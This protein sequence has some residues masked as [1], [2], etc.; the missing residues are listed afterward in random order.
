[1]FQDC[2]DRY[3]GKFKDLRI[4]GYGKIYYGNGDVYE[5]TLHVKNG[6]QGFGKLITMKKGDPYI[7]SYI[8]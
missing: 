8:G 1:M 3:I 6:K 4:Y 5:G 2:C 7:G